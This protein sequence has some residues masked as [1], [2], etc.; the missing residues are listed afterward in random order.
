MGN[1]INSDWNVP[2]LEDFK[3]IISKIDKLKKAGFTV[4][5]IHTI[6]SSQTTA[7]KG[8]RSSLIPIQTGHGK[9]INLKTLIS[10]PDG[11]QV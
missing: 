4:E 5:E 6:F 1:G 8:R 2:Q 3:K 11:K 10:E 7:A 9:L